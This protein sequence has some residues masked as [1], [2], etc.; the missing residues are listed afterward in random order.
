MSKVQNANIGPDNIPIKLNDVSNKKFVL[1]TN[2]YVVAT[3][4]GSYDKFA[5]MEM[6]DAV[7]GMVCNANKVD[8]GVVRNI[9]DPVQNKEL[10]QTAAGNWGSAIYKAFGFYTSYNGALAAW[11]I[12]AAE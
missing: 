7:I 3:T 1:T 10:N 2:S 11:A 4:D 8:F 9:S 12:A 5:A 6:D